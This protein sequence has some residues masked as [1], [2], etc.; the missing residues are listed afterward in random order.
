MGNRRCEPRAARRAS[1]AL[2][3][4]SSLRPPPNHRSLAR[5]HPRPARTAVSA[6]TRGNVAGVLRR[7]HAGGGTQQHG[8]DRLH[9]AWEGDQGT[10]LQ[11]EAT[12]CHVLRGGPFSEAASASSGTHLPLV[13]FPKT[14]HLKE[15]WVPALQALNPSSD[16]KSF[17]AAGGVRTTTT[18]AALRRSPGCAGPRPHP[19][20]ADTEELGRLRPPAG[21]GRPGGTRPVLPGPRGPAQSC[22]P[23][24]PS[25]RSLRGATWLV[26][27]LH[28]YTQVP[29]PTLS[30]LRDDQS[31]RFR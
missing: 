27:A 29:S 16:S 24:T 23:P 30:T 7:L 22:L 3:I 21:R 19:S 28:R 20:W 10:M 4:C 17:T 9:R 13:L 6:E 2:P 12:D 14:A 26:Q 1:E 5:E 31:T 25:A 8:D 18:D 15:Q 11:A